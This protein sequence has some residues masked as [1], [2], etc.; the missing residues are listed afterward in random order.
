[1]ME[2]KLKPASN[3]KRKL[4][5]REERYVKDVPDFVLNSLTSREFGFDVL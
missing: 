3:N 2:I 5:Y 1:M 4:F